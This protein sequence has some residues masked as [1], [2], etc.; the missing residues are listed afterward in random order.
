MEDPPATDAQVAKVRALRA[1][2]GED[3]GEPLPETCGEASRQLDRL[4]A[5]AGERGQ[6]ATARTPEG[7][8]RGGTPGT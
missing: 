2:L 6:D 5:H 3:E 4:K 7:R 1:A 8:F